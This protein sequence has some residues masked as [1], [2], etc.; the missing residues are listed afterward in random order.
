MKDTAP[1][2]GENQ[3]AGKVLDINTATIISTL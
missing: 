2:E 1:S 3:R